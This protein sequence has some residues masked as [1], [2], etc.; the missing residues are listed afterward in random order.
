MI[1]YISINASAHWEQRVFK[2]NFC[3]TLFPADV[4][5]FCP[6]KADF[7]YILVHFTANGPKWCLSCSLGAYIN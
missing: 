2:F 7:L 6:Y 5:V 4:R 1:N 3:S